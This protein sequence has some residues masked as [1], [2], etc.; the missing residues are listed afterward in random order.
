MAAQLASIFKLIDEFGKWCLNCL[1]KYNKWRGISH[2]H[3]VSFSGFD[4]DARAQKTP[5]AFRYRH[6][7]NNNFPNEC[8]K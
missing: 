6:W 3:V 5:C 4:H 2:V 7:R 8:L 1:K